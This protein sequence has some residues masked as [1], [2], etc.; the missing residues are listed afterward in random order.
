MLAAA[1]A[2]ESMLLAPAVSPVPQ[3]DCR[4]ASKVICQGVEVTQ[5]WSTIGGNF[6]SQSLCMIPSY[7]FFFSLPTAPEQVANNADAHPEG[8]HSVA[9]QLFW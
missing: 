9:L 3:S 7:S 1:A 5:P 8:V 2:A 4:R 6:L